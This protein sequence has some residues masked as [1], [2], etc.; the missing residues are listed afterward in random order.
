MAAADTDLLRLV[1]KCAKRRE[2]RRINHLLALP[3]PGAFWE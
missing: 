2:S 1:L 3:L